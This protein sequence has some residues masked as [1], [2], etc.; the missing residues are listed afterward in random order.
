MFRKI[1]DSLK[2]KY[3]RKD[4][5]SKQLDI[6]KV[7]DIYKKLNQGESFE[8]LAKQFSDDKSTAKNGGELSPFKSGQLGSETFESKAFNL[9]NN[10]DISAPFKTEYGWHIVKRISLKPNEDFEDVKS[11]LETKVK[12][13][14]RSK[15]IN[16]AMVKELKNRYNISSY[17]E[18]KS[19]FENL[20]NKD[21]FERSWTLPENL[22]TEKPVFKINNKIYT[23]QDFGKHLT[24]A[25]RI[26][27]GKSLPI[28][29]VVDTELE[30]FFEKSILQFREDNLENE[31]EAY[32]NILKEYRDGLL[33]FDLMEKEIW[34]KASKDSIGLEAFYARNKSNYQWDERVEVI[35]AS[36]ADE[37][38]V[39]TAQDMM[40]NEKSEEEIKKALNTEEV[41][42]IIFTSGTFT[43][44]NP[45]LPANFEV[46]QGISELYEHNEAFHVINVK[47]ILPSGPKTLEEA[48]GAV[49]NDYQ[50]ELEANWIN[51]LHKRYKVDINKKALKAIKAKI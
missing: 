14:S 20:I 30:S 11:A 19:Y 46:K 31:N 25:Q 29:T 27:S 51:D 24:N 22:E 10:G 38:M 15:L 33:L 39:K 18:A 36:S 47:A 49:I 28:A 4:E 6:V 2:A 42:N 9:E 26:Y 32:A 17:P 40:Q 7:F 34:N 8:A 41:Q 37:A 45:K 43:L 13:D 1:S 48:R 5:L 16:E 3:G 12:R 21:F 35:M 44:D 50:I 23:Y